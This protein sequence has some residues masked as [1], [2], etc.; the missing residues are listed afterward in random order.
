MGP[1]SVRRLTQTVREFSALLFSSRFLFVCSEGSAS[2]EFY[3]ASRLSPQA[4]WKQFVRVLRELG[5][6]PQRGGRLRQDRSLIRDATRILFHST[7]TV[8]DKT[9]ANGCRT[10]TFSRCCSLQK[11]SC[12]HWKTVDR[13]R[14]R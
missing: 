5:C 4:P 13:M 8:T 10:S 14:D 3:V 9:C 6:I 12:A 11:G 1:P 2:L 7:S